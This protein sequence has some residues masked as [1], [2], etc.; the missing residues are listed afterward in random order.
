MILLTFLF[1]FI[2]IILILYIPIPWSGSNISWKLKDHI[3]NAYIKYSHKKL[4]KP[5]NKKVCKENLESL[6]KILN[7]NKI[8]FWLSEGTALGARREGDFIDHD[9]D[10]DIGIWYKDY[11][12]FKKIIPLIIKKGFTIDFSFNGKK[13]KLTSLSRKYEKIDIDFTNDLYCEACNTKRAKCKTCNKLLKYLENMSYINFLGN[14]Y[15]CPDIDY[16]EYLYGP[17]WKTPRKEK[18]INI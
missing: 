10:V 2:L 4:N 13:T 1:I 15:L 3:K 5:L 9:D 8:T 6:S 16:L 18:F 11:D 14:K 7:D 12:K 17:D